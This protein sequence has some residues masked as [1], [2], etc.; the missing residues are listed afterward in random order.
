V[1]TPY[2]TPGLDL[3]GL[4]VRAANRKRPSMPSSSSGAAGS[5]SCTVGKVAH[6]DVSLR[7]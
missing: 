6:E 7:L 2:G 5:D 3:S 4:L 1:A